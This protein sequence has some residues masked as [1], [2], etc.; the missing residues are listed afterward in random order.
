MNG[1]GKWIVLA[2]VM[3]GTFL[4]RLDQ[5]VV[6]LG[7]PK[8]INDFGITVSAAGWIATAYILANAVFVPVWGKLGDTIGR[9]KVYVIGFLMFI[10]GSVLA[11]LSWNLPSMIVFRIIQAIAGSAD[12]PTAMA[13]L[14]VTFT[15]PRE[16]SQALGIWSASFAAAAVF[17]PLV[18]GPLIDNFGWRA[19][20]LVNLPVGVIGLLMALA[21]IN[22]SVSEK[23]TTV[24]DWWGAATLGASLSALVL[25]LDRG[26]DWGWLSLSS[27]LCY[28][29]S[30]L[31]L[32]I[33][34]QIETRHP[35]PI[36]DLK[37]F[38]NSV[39][40]NALVNNFIMFMGL[41]GSI[42]LLP[43]FAQT[44]LGYDATETGYLFIPMAFGL[45]FTAPFGG[46]LTGKV[47]T[48]YVIF[49]STFLAGC[50]MYLFSYIDPRSSALDL[51]I[52]LALMAGAMGF[53]MAG[54]TSVV[55]ASVEEHEIG[56]ASA[57][58]ALARNIAGAFGIALFGTILNNAIE[59][60]V[61]SIAGQSIIR[62]S[63]PT[64][65]QQGIALIELKAQVSAYGQVYAAAAILIILG[66]F[67]ALLMKIP[68]ARE[69]E[70]REMIVE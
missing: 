34:I 55:A 7:L 29:A 68:K 50:A 22:E 31:F 25:V 30:L 23:K 62:S 63:D 11:G 66:S 67:T 49:W 18:G 9:K 20:F 39:F 65:I 59:S 70:K 69:L 38:K 33:F 13:I 6:N 15:E 4:G 46:M 1:S 58:L 14:A 21:F 41:M 40:V 51:M 48:R 2:T 61:L 60:N 43:I 45:L 42:F 47:Q 37:F 10:V 64:I 57:V 3:V 17:G 27:M 26:L 52:P 16:R 54:R 24:F 32:W 5:T 44:F 28:A 56:T 36:V 53:G 19:V 8:I 12:Y 35:E